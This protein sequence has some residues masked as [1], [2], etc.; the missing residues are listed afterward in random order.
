[1][2]PTVAGRGFD[3]ARLVPALVGCSTAAVILVEPTGGSWRALPL[4]LAGASVACGSSQTTTATAHARINDVAPVVDADGS[5]GWWQPGDAACPDDATL[6]G[7]AP[8]AGTEIGCVKP[9]G[10]WHG[11]R[12]AWF[13]DC[14]G[15]RPCDRARL[16]IKFEGSYR[17][18]IEHGHWIWWRQTGGKGLEG[19]YFAGRKVGVWWS[20]DERG[21]SHKSQLEAPPPPSADVDQ[22]IREA[23]AAAAKVGA[24]DLARELDSASRDLRIA[25]AGPERPESVRGLTTAEMKSIDIRATPG[26]GTVANWGTRLPSPD[27]G[28][29]SFGGGRDRDASPYIRAVTQTVTVRV[30]DCYRAALAANRSLAGQI[31]AR[32]TIDLDGNVLEARV[33]HSDLPESMN[34]CVH[35]SIAGVSFEPHN[36]GQDIQ[37]TTPWTFRAP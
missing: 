19:N 30:V 37:V 7:A 17:R 22:A 31:T 23:L 11:L 15:R 1:V 13:S 35:D 29:I 26:S 36:T 2:K 27:I 33:V 4:I 12:T 10:V 3:T 16:P 6:R 20:W 32:Y 9:S 25:R 24:K 14:G 34:Q 28:R 18:G 21:G 5:D 8:P